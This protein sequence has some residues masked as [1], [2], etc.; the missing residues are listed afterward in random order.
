MSEGQNDQGMTY[1]L[2]QQSGTLPAI[3][4]SRGGEG[5]HARSRKAVF[6]NKIP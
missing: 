1:S 2:L 3:I 4:G 6:M 5:D